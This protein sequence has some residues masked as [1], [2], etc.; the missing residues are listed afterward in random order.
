M[1]EFSILYG[2][3]TIPSAVVEEPS[4]FLDGEDGRLV[5]GSALLCEDD[6]V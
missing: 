1:G 3:N 2:A 6:D 4:F 5:G